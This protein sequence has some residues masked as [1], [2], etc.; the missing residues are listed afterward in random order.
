MYDEN[1]MCINFGCICNCRKCDSMYDLKCKE[2]ESRN[3]RQ[4]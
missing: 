1:D 4:G 2:Y 3:T